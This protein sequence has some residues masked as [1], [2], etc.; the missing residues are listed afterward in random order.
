MRILTAN[1]VHVASS[2]LPCYVREAD[3]VG[4]LNT[5]GLVA[6]AFTLLSFNLLG[7]SVSLIFNSLMLASAMNEILQCVRKFVSRSLVIN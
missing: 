7:W 3:E 4:N 2:V 6:V 1:A 5:S